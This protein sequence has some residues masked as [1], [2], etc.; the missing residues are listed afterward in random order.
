MPLYTGAAPLLPFRRVSKQ[1]DE[2]VTSST[3]FQNDDEL[4][5]SVAANAE[6]KVECNIWVQGQT[7]DSV[8]KIQWPSI[9]GAS[10]QWTF[11]CLSSTA[12][13]T[14]SSISRQILQFGSS[15]TTVCFS[16]NDTWA[17]CIGYLTMGSTAGSLQ[18][19]WA[20]N[21]SSA[22]ATGVKAGSSLELIQ[23]AF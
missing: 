6:Y 20:Q 12:T 15:A 23:T 2:Y 3:T 22:N 14:T 21:V 13:G 11:L 10:F 1:T 4:L 7:G 19:Q 16:A 5:I 9:T 17:T 18:L 8:L